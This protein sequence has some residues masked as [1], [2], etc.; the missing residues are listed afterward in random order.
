MPVPV[1]GRRHNAHQQLTAEPWRRR[2]LVE[3]ATHLSRLA[4]IERGEARE[5]LLGDNVLSARHRPSPLPGSLDSN[6]L[7]HGP[8]MGIL[9]SC[10]HAT[11]FAQAGNGRA[12]GMRQPAKPLPDLR[13][14]SALGSLEHADQ[15]RA[16]GCW[17]VP[18]HRSRRSS[19]KRRAPL[20]LRA[21]P[22]L[23]R[24]V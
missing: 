19:P 6:E 7:V 2:R 15:L 9:A 4:N 3:L 5:R 21:R 20:W 8:I 14:R 16:L 11:G 22:S 12:H 13:H 17:L 18:R 24:F 23:L 1:S 10:H